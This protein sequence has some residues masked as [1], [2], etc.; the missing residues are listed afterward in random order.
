MRNIKCNNDNS[1]NSI[2][3]KQYD[4]SLSDVSSNPDDMNEIG[5][6]DG[7]NVVSDSESTDHYKTT[8]DESCVNET[9]CNESKNDKTLRIDVE[10][11]N[12]LINNTND[13]KN[14]T[15]TSNTRVSN[16]TES[17][18]NKRDISSNVNNERVGFNL[19]SSCSNQTGDS[20]NNSLVLKLSRDMGNSVK[21]M[22]IMEMRLV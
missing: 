15:G 11:D 2:E 18:L 12:A 14:R 16:E 4:M 5:A 7:S 8:D 10:N 21:S 3:K 6:D 1:D 22:M 13:N 19:S 9:D 20:G 17:N